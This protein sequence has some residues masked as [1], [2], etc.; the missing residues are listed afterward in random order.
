MTNRFQNPELHK[1]LK[2]ATKDASGLL[3]SLVN[4]LQAVPTKKIYTL[5]AVN[6]TQ[7]KADRKLRKNIKTELSTIVEE[8]IPN[9]PSF[10]SCVEYLIDLPPLFVP[11]LKLE[12]VFI[13]TVSA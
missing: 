4:K 1:Y 12:F 6:P 8:T 7:E 3:K 5:P 10:K 2:A 11:P 13:Q 9:E